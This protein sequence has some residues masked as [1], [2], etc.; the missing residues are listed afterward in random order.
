MPGDLKTTKR[1]KTY[2][3]FQPMTEN[4]AEILYSRRV[5]RLDDMLMSG[6][7]TQSAYD[8]AMRQLDEEFRPIFARCTASIPDI[9]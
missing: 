5:D 7:L 3:E 9:T 1:N 6:K 8:A 2:L 4:T